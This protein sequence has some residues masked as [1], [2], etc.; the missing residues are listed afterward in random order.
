M[1]QYSGPYRK[2]YAKRRELLWR[3]RAEYLDGLR[4][5]EEILEASAAPPDGQ[6][7]GTVT[8][9]PTL[10]KA[11]RLTERGLFCDI[12]DHAL[13]V[14]PDE[15]RAGVKYAAIFGHPYPSWAALKTWQGYQ[16]R[17][18]DQLAADLSERTTN[19][20]TPSQS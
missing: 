16:R 4:E 13:K 5:R 18:L 1:N 11:V 14:V 9:D 15:Y 7:R 3:I 10:S 17:F 20:S 8:S 12:V 6:P 19:A 2:K